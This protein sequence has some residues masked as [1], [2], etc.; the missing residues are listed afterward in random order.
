MCVSRED[1][2]LLSQ[3]ISTFACTFLMN[4]MLPQWVVELIMQAK[5]RENKHKGYGPCLSQIPSDCS[6]RCQQSK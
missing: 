1:V 5:E 4:F 6:A 2:M 3:Y